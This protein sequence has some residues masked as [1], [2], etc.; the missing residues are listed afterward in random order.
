MNGEIGYIAVAEP[1]PVCPPPIVND[2]AL[3]QI[4]QNST[5]HQ[6]Q[7][8]QNQ[9]VSPSHQHQHQHQQ[10][11]SQQLYA[12]SERMKHEL[13]QLQRKISDLN[14]A[15]RDDDGDGATPATSSSSSA[16]PVALNQDREE[17]AGAE[18]DA[19]ASKVVVAAVSG[20]KHELAKELKMIES[21]IR[22]REREITVNHLRIAAAAA[23]SCD[24]TVFPASQ[25]K[26]LKGSLIFLRILILIIQKNES[27]SRNGP[28]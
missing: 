28:L 12:E 4:Q 5:L 21:T 3:Q 16:A 2:V 18:G 1:D 27:I 15:R 24:A 20:N 23:D 22:D 10:Q 7:Q 25:G 19:S 11:Y 8:N 26:K 9:G 6:Q 14:L 17:K 13:E